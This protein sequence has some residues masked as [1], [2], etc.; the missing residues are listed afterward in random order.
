[1][2]LGGFHDDAA[3]AAAQTEAGARAE[4]ARDTGTP[5]TSQPQACP[6]EPLGEGVVCAGCRGRVSDRYFLLAVD[7]AWHRACLRCSVCQEE[8]ESQLTCFSKN[9]AIYCREDYCRLFSVGRCARCAQPIPS[10][11]LVMR[12]GALTFHPHCFSC[13]AC[14]AVL[15]PGDLYSLRGRSL[16]CQA[17]CHGNRPRPRRQRLRDQEPEGEPAEGE[18]PVSSPEPRLAGGEQ[19]GGAGGR[20]KRI[21]TCFKSHQLR[22]MESYFAMKHNPDGKDWACLASR[23]G[24]PKRVLQVWFQN[25][26]A[27]LRRSLCADD[28]QDSG[29]PPP[30]SADSGSPSPTGPAPALASTIDQSELSLL[31][32]PLLAPPP[33]VG[34]GLGEAIGGGG[35]GG[36]LGSP[37]SGSYY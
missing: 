23:T 15:L 24:L 35:G 14:G 19:G 33:F 1:M 10:S 36:H 2:L 29:T 11:A 20:A 25:A 12:S 7:R 5:G 18:E 9:S 37:A 32:A 34:F 3:A 17:H 27:K 22:A 13:Q 4:G 31:T 30:V 16:Y 8:L 6:G 28:S 26:R 21:R